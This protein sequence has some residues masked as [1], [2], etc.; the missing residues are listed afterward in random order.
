LGLGALSQALRQ[1]EGYASCH[2]WAASLVSELT[3]HP[4]YAA[5]HHLLAALTVPRSPSTGTEPTTTRTTVVTASQ[6]GSPGGVTPGP[7]V[8]GPVVPSPVIDDPLSVAV[9]GTLDITLPN[10]GL[11][12]SGLTFTITPQPLGTGRK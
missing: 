2:G 1:H 12:T 6:S 11:G 7:A 4:R 8:V 9:G 3:A 10:L 5:A